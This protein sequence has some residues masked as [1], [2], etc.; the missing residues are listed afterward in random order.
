[1]QASSYR[2]EH[3]DWCNV[4]DELLILIA[5]PN[6]AKFGTNLSW[7]LDGERR[8]NFVVVFSVER[9]CVYSTANVTLNPKTK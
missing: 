5:R 7:G 8:P 2:F 6:G 9:V 3:F 1:M 4:F